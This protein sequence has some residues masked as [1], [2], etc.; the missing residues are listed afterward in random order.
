LEAQALSGLADAAYAQGR[1][2]TAKRYFRQCVELAGRHGFRRIEV[3]NLSMVAWSRF[4]AGEVREAYED[5]LATIEAA[6]EAGDLRAE[7]IG[8]CILHVASV[9]MGA[10]AD[11]VQEVSRASDLADRLGAGRFIAQTLTFQAT[12]LRHEGRKEEARRTAERAVALSLESGAAFNAPRALSELAFNLDDP[13]ERR[14]CLDRGEAYLRD[15]AVA[16]NH[17]T[18]YPDALEICLEDEDLTAVERYAQALEDFTRQEPLV[19]CDFYIARARALVRHRR[20]E[21]GPEIRDE[22]ERLCTQARECAFLIALPKLEA[23]LADA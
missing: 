8:R 10:P 16:H 5:G 1:A 21:R 12:I 15:G 18:F 7:L 17:F 20:G 23:A 14:A 4:F 11:A 19:R 3:V 13:A 2:I 22:L 9:Q 6:A